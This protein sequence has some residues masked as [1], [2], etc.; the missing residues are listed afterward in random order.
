M[1]DPNFKEKH[2][3][4]A[5]VKIGPA[6]LN[7]LDDDRKVVVPLCACK[8]LTVNGQIWEVLLS[9]FQATEQFVTTIWYKQPSAFTRVSGNAVPRDE[10]GVVDG[11]DVV[12][13]P[14]PTSAP[15]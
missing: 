15:Q 10:S 11:S 2:Y 9:V 1:P 6:T 3:K 7:Y 4:H 14:P 5:T 8:V 13:D 12:E